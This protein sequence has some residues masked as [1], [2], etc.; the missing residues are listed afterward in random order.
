M[1]L[2]VAGIIFFIALH[3]IPF[4]GR[5]VRSS[6]RE[7][8]GTG[9][10]MGIFSLLLVSCFV[11]MVLGWRSST[12]ELLYVAPAW[13]RV[14]T[15]LLSVVGLLLFI[16]SNAPTN[17]RRWLRHPQLLGLG[18]WSVGHLLSNGELRSVLL[19]G[20]MGLFA[21]LA[22]LLSNRRDGVWQKMDAVP[23]SKDVTV[24]LI[25]LVVCAAL[26]Y[27]HGSISGIPL[28]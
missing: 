7:S 18:L 25:G 20:G 1:T 12:A 21:L 13:G 28:R 15:Y 27:F 6:L 4:L 2:L 8:I 24:V 3:M 5:D 17:I 11:L 14:L 16:A 10:Y 22:I 23:V 26:Y 9:P 19:F